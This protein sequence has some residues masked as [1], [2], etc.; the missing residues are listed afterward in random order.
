MSLL[1]VSPRN[2]SYV[3]VIILC[4]QHIGV[5][6]VATLDTLAWNFTSTSSQ[7]LSQII[8]GTDSPLSTD[9]AS[10]GSMVPEIGLIDAEDNR[11]RVDYVYLMV[12]TYVSPFLVVI[13]TVGNLLSLVVLQSKHFRNAPSSFIMSALACTDTGVLLCGVSRH[14]ILALTDYGI[15]IRYLSLVSCWTHY[16]FMYVLWELSSWSLALLTIERMASVKWPFK[17]RELFSKKKMVIAWATVTLCLVTINL[18][19]F[20]TVK[21]TDTY[22]DYVEGTQF[23]LDHMWPWIDLVLSSL[24]PLTIITTCNIIIISTL[25]RARKKRQEQM[26]VTTQTDESDSI[27]A[28]LVGISIT[29]FVATLPICVY[30]I[31]YNYWTLETHDQIYADWAA[32]GVTLI[33]YY[34]S[35]STNFIVYCVSGAKFRRALVA[36]L[37]CREI[38]KPGSSRSATSKTSTTVVSKANTT[39]AASLSQVVTTVTT[40]T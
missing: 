20:V 7:E 21:Y 14:W 28:M 23:F 36:V 34:C 24:A 15:D 39:E 18:H 29:F 12:F 25:L 27:T 32:Y 5:M 35:S 1:A 19:W 16:F 2:K 13:G 9:N 11:R 22:C 26:K 10:S 33:L 17:A 31:G 38:A 6:A 4:L 30:L 37:C 3:I 40:V 8:N